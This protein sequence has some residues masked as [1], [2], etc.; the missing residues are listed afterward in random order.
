MDQFNKIQLDAHN[1]YRDH[2]ATAPLTFNSE[3]ASQ[4][5]QYACELAIANSGLK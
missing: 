1:M 3:L 5:Y 4:A 2:H